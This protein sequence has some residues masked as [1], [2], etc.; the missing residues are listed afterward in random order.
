MPGRRMV[1]EYFALT[2][3]AFLFLLP[4]S[5]TA[6]TWQPI[7][8]ED[9]ALKD[10]PQD[11]GAD[12]MVLYRENFIDAKTARFSGDSDEEFMRIKVFTQAGT[13]HAH[14]EIP[15]N[16]DNMEVKDLE[17]RT[18]KPDGTIIKF[19]GQVL[20]TTAAKFAGT[21][22]LVKALTLPDVTP[23]CIIEYK[24][25]LQGKPGWV[26]NEGWTISSEMFTREAHFRFRPDTSYGAPTAFYRRIRVPDAAVLK[27][28]L[29]GTYTLD[30][31]NIPAVVDEPLMPPEAA[32]ETRVEFY[33]K[34]SGAV[35]E[36]PAA[37]WAHQTKQW[38]G[39]IDHFL[40]KKSVLAQEVGKVVAPSDDP[41]TKLRKIYARVLQVRNLS[42]EDSKTEKELKAE[43]VKPNSNVED[44]LNRNAGYGRE[45]DFLYVG[46]A[47]AAGFPSAEIY[48]AAR[49][50]DTFSPANE[51]A[52]QLGSDIVWVQAGGRDYYLDPGSRYYPFGVLPWSETDCAGIRIG[53]SNVM[54]ATTPPPVASDATL[55]RKADLQ[56]ADDGSVSGSIQI[57]FGGRRGAM[58]REAKRKEDE[59]GR[60]KDLEEE[61]KQWLPVGSTFEI[62]KLEN[63]DDIELPV[64]VT[65]SL[66]ISTFGTGAVRHLLIPREIFQPMQ[67]A[68][69]VAEKRVN[70]VY[71]EYAFEEIDDITIRAPL[72]F[73]FQALPKDQKIDL[74]AVLYEAS[75]TQ[76][77]D[78]VEVKRHL[79]LNGDVFDQKN[80]PTLRAF[81]G[82][83]RTD[84][85]VQMVL[86]NGQSAHN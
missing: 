16:K 22:I 2:F 64:R 21:R 20:E 44:L 34:D 60:I 75:S 65:G 67:A 42:V 31:T 8:P 39:E 36:P 11:P 69:F 38:N 58:L 9:L 7:P 46:L 79:V 37:F 76:R 84:D 54:V 62:S 55:T 18:I 61:V 77:P 45:I 70:P 78:G 57:D 43:S 86:E 1:L 19:E 72:G 35:T 27:T 63:W 85:A 49:T 80:Y 24:Y 59:T 29:D 82:T 13:K 12:A 5:A 15:F 14:V 50:G 33:Y 52:D 6:Q 28:Q 40:D 66:K 48:L 74:K 32:L 68:D 17:G 73:S 81:F 53:S 26:H 23:G 3:F 51:D 83:V 41:E 25:R 10:S 71:F 56:L 47:R 30:I 4:Y